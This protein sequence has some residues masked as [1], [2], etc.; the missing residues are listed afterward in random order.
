MSK[1]IYL[2]HEYEEKSHFKA[3]YE[4]QQENGI[5]IEDFIILSKNFLFRRFIKNILKEKN[6]YNHLKLLIKEFSKQKS[7][8]KLKN[9][10]LIVGLAPYD[11]LLLKYEPVFRNNKCIY[12]TSWQFWDGIHFPKGKLKNK[13]NFENI[14]RKYFLGAACVSEVTSKELKNIISNRVVVNH[15]IN[16]KEYMKKSLDQVRNTKKFIFLGT[17][18]DRKNVPLIIDWIRG[19]QDKKFDFYFAGNGEYEGEIKKLSNNFNN[20]YFLGRLSKNQIK[21]S[22][23]NYDFIVLP[24]KEE[25]FGI[26]LLEALASGVPAI[27]SNALGPKEIITD[28]FNGLMF[29]NESS[30]TEFNQI[31]NKAI[32]MNNED[33]RKMVENCI[34]SSEKYDTSNI[35]NKWLSLINEYEEKA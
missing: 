28:N 11:S 33:Y 23:C 22:L 15:S 29:K 20:I 31:M 9:E 7:L 32:H 35:I 1:K 5:I 25:P 34:K 18:N 30:S 8:K 21:E 12:F 3:L 14:L 19:N 24:S 16:T 17:F 4:L 26:V 2:L 27:V 13:D 10:I 6:I